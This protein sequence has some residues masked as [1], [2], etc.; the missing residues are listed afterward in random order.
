MEFKFNTILRTHFY[1][2]CAIILSFGIFIGIVIQSLLIPI[3]ILFIF[4]IFLYFIKTD[5]IYIFLLAGIIFISGWFI[6]SV[7][8]FEINQ[9]LGYIDSLHGKSVEF[10]AVILDTKETEHGWRANCEIL[11]LSDHILN[12]SFILSVYG[13]GMIPSDGDSILSKG[14][15]KKL[16]QLRNPGDF[17]FRSHFS[18]L[19]NYG[20][21]FI[22]KKHSVII[23]QGKLSLYKR[24]IHNSQAF[25][26]NSVN[27]ATD[28]KTA[29]LL[30][31]LLLGDKTTIDEEMKNDFANTGVIHVLAVSGLH[32][33]YIL[34]ILTIFT[35]I[36]RIPWGWNRVLIILGLIAFCALTGGKP[37][38]IRAS[39][40]AGLYVLTP[41]VNRPGNIWNIIGFAACLLLAY[42]PLYIMG[43]G[44]I[45]SFS[46]VV[47]IIYFYG[48]FEKLLPESINPKYI[49]NSFIKNTVSLF[50]VSL[51]A[52]IGTLP[53]TASYFHKIPIISLLANVII[54]PIIGLIVVVG[55]IILGFSFS[56][57]LSE[58]AGNVAETLQIII[59]WFAQFFSSFSFS[60][61]SISQVTFVDIILYSL[62]IIAL[63]YLF[64]LKYRGKGIIALLL[65]SNLMIWGNISNPMTNI[66]YMDVGQGDAALIQ[67]SNGKTMLVDAGNR[68]RR[69]DWGERVVIPV[70][71]YLE[72]KKLEWVVMSHPHADHIGGLVSIVEQI[73]ADTLMDTY[74]GYGSWTYNHLIETYN[75]L[76]TIIKIPKAGE[77]L[78]I[79]PMESIYFLAPDSLFSVSQHNVNNASIVFKLIVGKKSFL[80]TGDLEHEG[81]RALIQYNSYLKVDVL[82]VGHHGSITS[83][84]ENVLAKMNPELAVVSVGDGNKFSHPSP[85]VMDRLRTHQIKIHRTDYSGALWLQTDGNSYWKKEWK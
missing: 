31:A 59:S 82:K 48:L 40:M 14:E 6:S 12:R 72:I 28:S 29:G 50:L 73:P 16:S 44:F 58:L 39:I 17:D 32:V 77:V 36:I 66:I 79:T 15:I 27:Q 34:I 10:S 65:M 45:L 67:F 21:L 60:L 1:F 52:Q 30:T 22:D 62:L 5:T 35:S 47:S 51:S 83:T 68:N 84:T 69:E 80:F 49:K 76:G 43:L 81:D 74:S 78:Q 75:E 85:V 13:K 18:G 54:V 64:Q 9:K 8:I 38:V 26:R 33:G 55:F 57:I 61:I 11:S 3:I 4:F 20:R 53:I 46:A 71:N 70:L 23:H 41:I 7:R 63:F 2:Y 19:G 37:S 42:D 24:W 56:P 25:V